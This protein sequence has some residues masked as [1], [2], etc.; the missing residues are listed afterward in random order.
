[1]ST[2]QDQFPLCAISLRI[3]LSPSLLLWGRVTPAL[4]VRIIKGNL[5]PETRDKVIQHTIEI[6]KDHYAFPETG[7]EIADSIKG[8]MELGEYSEIETTSA[9]CAK[10]RDDLTAVNQDKHLA[11]LY[12]P[13]GVEQLT[14]MKGVDDGD[15]WYQRHQMNNF[16]MIRAEYLTGNVGYLDIRIFAPLSKARDATIHMMSYISNC[17]ALIIDVRNHGGGDPHTSQLIQSYF[18][19]EKPKLLLTLYNRRK[20]THEQIRTIPH[21]PGK[22]LP[23]IPLYILTSKKSFSGAEGFS[24]SLKHHGRALIVGE[25][26]G[27]GAHT[28]DQ[29]IVYDGFVINIPTGYPTHPETGGNWEGV[30]VEP[31]IIVPRDEALAVAHTH[32]IEA[33]ISK[34]SDKARI[35]KLTF[36][37]ERV[38]AMYS[39]ADVPK[40]TLKE[41]VGTY[42]SY[43]VDFKG[44]D[45]CIYSSKED[46]IEWLLK[47]LTKTLFAI[48]NDDYNVRFDTDDSE[49]G[50]SLVFLHWTQEEEHPIARSRD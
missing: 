15:L 13:E 6:V 32:A 10:L 18:F 27:G 17:D 44:P 16:G 23:S 7:A 50:T 5:A 39:P 24:Y 33:L 4:S 19:D 45:L 21:L 41:Y 12:W 1:M 48:E 9:L 14:A 34:E 31:D 37:L 11:V 22:R 28:I 29:M 25:T 35:R 2:E 40:N 42:G 8:K 49:R 46:S 26:T 38:R 47:P 20:D 30:G 36:E 43:S 3:L